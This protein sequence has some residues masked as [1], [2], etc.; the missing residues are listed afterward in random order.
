MTTRPVAPKWARRAASSV[1]YATAR[2]AM[3]AAWNAPQ[4]AIEALV[5]RAGGYP[6]CDSQTIKRSEQAHQLSVLRDIVGNPF[7]RAVANPRWQRWGGGLIRTLA[8]A[9]Y[10]ERRFADLPVLADALEEAG[11]RDATI[12]QHARSGGSHA[13]GCWLLDHILNQE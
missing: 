8:A 10:E 2:D 5:W 9:I 12:L 1:Y 13:R 11:C 6:T 3:E 4:L 7:S